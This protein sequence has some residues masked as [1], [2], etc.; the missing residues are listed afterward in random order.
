MIVPCPECSQKNRVPA[1]RLG[2][3]PTCGEC[4]TSL[5]D[6]SAPM[7]VESGE[8]DDLINGSDRPVFVDFWAPWCGPCKMVAPEV[9]ELAARHRGDLLVVKVN[10]E[11]HPQVAQSQGIRGIPM[12]GLFENGER[13]NEATGY[14][15]ADKLETVFKL[16]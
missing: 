6:P 16:Q 10:T 11:D 2:D 14:M 9:E 7:T 4:H 12:F 1:A 8:F 13:V 5:D 15:K 3:G